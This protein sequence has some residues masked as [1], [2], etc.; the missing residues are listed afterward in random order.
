MFH[1]MWTAC[2]GLL[3]SGHLH[4]KH[5]FSEG[6]LTFLALEMKRQT[7]KEKEVKEHLKPLTKPAESLKC[8]TV[9]WGPNC[10][11]LKVKRS[12]DIEIENCNV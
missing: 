2:Y 8:Q 3:T 12:R 5:W 7:I 9:L 1:T 11:L 6:K 4:V 10:A